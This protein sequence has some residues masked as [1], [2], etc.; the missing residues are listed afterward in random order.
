MGGR[1]L[2]PKARCFVIA[3]V[4][5]PLACNAKP[6]IDLD[7]SISQCIDVKLGA[8]REANHRFVTD[9]HIVLKRELHECGCTSRQVAYLVEDAQR[10]RIAHERFTLHGDMQRQI[11]LGRSDRTLRNSSMKL[12]IGCSG[13]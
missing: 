13:A 5:V 11:N 9:A 10:R 7:N 8:P 12:M 1:S 4:L 3:L 2:F 6:N